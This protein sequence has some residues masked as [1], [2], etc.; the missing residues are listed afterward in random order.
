MLSV[1]SLACSAYCYPLA[2][3][4]FTF[5]CIS[6]LVYHFATPNRCNNI[7]LFSALL[8]VILL[9][10]ACPPLPGSPVGE[11]SH[12]TRGSISLLISNLFACNLCRSAFPLALSPVPS[13]YG[14]R[15]GSRFPPV[16]EGSLTR[17]SR[18]GKAKDG[19]G[20]R[21]RGK[22]GHGGH[23][24]LVV[25]HCCLRLSLNNDTVC[26]FFPLSLKK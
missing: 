14:H 17:A 5:L 22:V 19:R 18:T 25:L 7:S 1:P 2:L 3:S 26:G 23:A 24:T 20:K 12:R 15:S 11:K 21:R 10:R 16:G 6:L 9:I 8:F 4:H 13:H